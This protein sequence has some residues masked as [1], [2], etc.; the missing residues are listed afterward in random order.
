MLSVSRPK[1]LANI[2]RVQVLA[3]RH[4]LR[5]RPHVKTHKS[6]E[7]ARLQL[8]AGA[9][10]LTASRPAEALAFLRQGLGPVTIAYPVVDPSLLDDPIKA[11]REHGL[12]LRA[13]VDSFEGYDA[14]AHASSAYPLQ[15]ML[16]IDVGLHRC[17]VDV[18]DPRLLEIPRLIDSH[19]RLHFAGII[20]HAGQ[21][22]GAAGKEAVTEIAE[23]ERLLMLEAKE[24]IERDGIAVEEISVG[25]TPT[26]LSASSFDGITE[27]RPG[28]YVFF[29]RTQIALGSCTLEDVALTV[30]ATVIS[31][32][33]RYHIV[34][35]GSKT[36]SSDRGAH[37][38]STIGGF[39]LV[40]SDRELPEPL[41]LERLSE[42][43]GFVA[44]G[45]TALPIG[46]RVTIIPNHACVVA[47]LGREYDVDGEVWEVRR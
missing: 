19:P 5:L 43:H 30:S 23:S 8:A 11:A 39:G 29:D 46:S 40:F 2:D 16:K 35:A 28:N 10:G 24:R 18:G 33:P 45:E 7:I 26:V 44:R 12:P 15:V 6:L 22:Y 38:A 3:D 17:G 20:S 31:S 14:L 41:I 13:I 1:L 25:S 42:E 21:A 34:D 32:N 4:G 47:N 36:L 27:V 37:G 9:T